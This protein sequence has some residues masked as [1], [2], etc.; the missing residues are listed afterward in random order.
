MNPWTTPIVV[1]LILTSASAGCVGKKRDCTDEGPANLGGQDLRVLDNGAWDGAYAFI[2]PIFEERTGSRLVQIRAED[3]GAALKQVQ[4]SKGA[5]VADLIYGVD[6]ALFAQG[7]RAGVFQ[8]YESPRLASIDTAVIRLN[9]FRFNGVLLATP[10]DHGFV[11]VNYDRAIRD[12]A[13]E[14][15][16]PQTLRD[17]A[18]ASWASQLV[19]EDPRLST[20]GLGF[21]VAT[22]A[23]FG[24]N[25]DYDYLDFWADLLDHG[26][27]VAQDWT[28]AYVVHFSAGYGRGSEGF[29]GDRR[30]VVSYTTSPAAEAYYGNTTPP[31]VSFEPAFGVFHQVETV[32]IL[33][34][35]PHV[36][37]AKAFVDLL[38]EPEYQNA[39]AE[40]MAVYPV[41]QNATMPE[42]F[43][44]HATDPKDLRPAPFTGDDLDRNVPRWLDEWTS[45]YQKHQ[46]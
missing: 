14:G 26:A 20:P 37:L 25:G 4:D 6:N 5:P 1:L 10:V 33:Q 38:L 35:T 15:A 9:D 44:M 28:E 3:A 34:C 8:A 18:G 17:L 19:V 23:T 45:V 40:N 29:A 16:L 13:S 32:A 31:S 12:E 7:A 21:L 11:G 36:A 43:T 30:L 39:A 22:V 46:A 42:A 41:T 27:L 24:E 2:K